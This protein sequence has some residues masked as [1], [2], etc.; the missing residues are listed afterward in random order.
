MRTIIFAFIVLMFQMSLC[1]ESFCFSKLSHEESMQDWA[2]EYQ[3]GIAFAK[4]KETSLA[5]TSFKRAL[6]LSTDHLERQKEIYYAI[7]LTYY[8]AEK[9]ASAV[10]MFEKSPL[11]TVNEQFPSYHDLMIM[12]YHSYEIGKAPLKADLI[13]KQIEAISPQEANQL[14]ITQALLRKDLD[15]IKELSASLPNK[16]WLGD[17]TNTLTLRQKS[18][19]LAKYLNMFVPGLGY[20]YLGQKKAAFTAFAINTTLVLGAVQLFMMRYYALA[21]LA[22]LFE[23][24]WY[25]GGLY[26]AGQS[27]EVYNEALFSDYADQIFYQEDLHFTSKLKYEF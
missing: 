3:M 11:L 16:K 18:Q 15:Q 12:L 14:K 23:L 24:G 1:A 26:G 17:L 5:I 20:Y 19:K 7:I 21:S 9:Y 6:V 2:K 10:E 13:L 27:T 8:L 22:T 4:E 25:V